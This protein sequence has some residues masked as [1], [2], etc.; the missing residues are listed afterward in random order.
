MVAVKDSSMTLD[1][2]TLKDFVSCTKNIIGM[3]D[4]HAQLKRQ[5]EDF[6][7]LW[8]DSQTDFISFCICTILYM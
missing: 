5:T 6:F 7:L 4:Q 2:N 1:G 3:A 8:V